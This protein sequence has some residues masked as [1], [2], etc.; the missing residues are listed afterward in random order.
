V[1]DIYQQVLERPADPGSAGFSRALG[2]GEMTVRDVVVRLAQSPEHLH[3][4]SWQPVIAEIYRQMLNRPPSPEEEQAAARM[5]ASRMSIKGLAARVAVGAANNEADAVRILYQRLLGRDPDPE[6]MRANVTLAQR[7]GIEAVVRSMMSSPEYRMR[8][9]DPASMRE[10]AAAY[11][12]GVQMLYRHMLNRDP[13]PEGFASMSQLAAVY[14]LAE[15]A[16]RIANSREYMQRWGPNKVPGDSGIEFCG[17]GGSRGRQAIPR[18]RDPQS[19]EGPARQ[20]WPTFE[21]N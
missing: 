5:L 20:R 15:V 11:R 3:R 14:G 13:D 1:D 7:N 12:T 6:G 9:Q 4:F 10:D 19:E 2:S 16:H 21:R 18:P 17:V 8:A